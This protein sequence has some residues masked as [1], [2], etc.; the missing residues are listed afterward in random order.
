MICWM[1]PAPVNAWLTWVASTLS[2][3]A[4]ARPASR[5][6]WKRGGMSRVKV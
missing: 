2:W 6:S 4:G 5:S 3:M 1:C